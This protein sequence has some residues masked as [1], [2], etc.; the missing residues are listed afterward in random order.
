MQ[1]TKNL[2]LWLIN[3]IA[4]WKHTS[5]QQADEPAWPIQ[6]DLRLQFECYTYLDFYFLVGNPDSNLEDSEELL[7]EQ[8]SGHR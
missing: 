2:P 4:G 1:A 7:Q 6:L 8:L 5:L 3:G